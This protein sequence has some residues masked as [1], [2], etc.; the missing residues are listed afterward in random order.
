[1][2]HIPAAPVLFP[3]WHERTMQYP[4]RSEIGRTDEKRSINL[5][6]NDLFGCDIEIADISVEKVG[7][8]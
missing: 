5:N 4:Y 7:M 2:Q 6:V 8:Q 3:R 1:M